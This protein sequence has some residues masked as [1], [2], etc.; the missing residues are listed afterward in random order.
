MV[1]VP[2]FLRHTSNSRLQRNPIEAADLIASFLR[3]CG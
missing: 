3:R 2:G 1:R